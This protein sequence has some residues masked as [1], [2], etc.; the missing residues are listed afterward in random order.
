MIKFKKNYLEKLRTKWTPQED[1]QLLTNIIKYG[2]RWSYLSKMIKGRNEHSIKYHFFALLKKNGITLGEDDTEE[3]SSSNTMSEIFKILE[4][5]NKNTAVKISHNTDDKTTTLNTSSLCEEETTVTLN[6]QSQCSLK[7]N[8]NPNKC[9]GQPD[10][11][12]FRLMNYWH[13]VEEQRM[14]FQ[15]DL[16]LNSKFDKYEA[17]NTINKVFFKIY[18][19]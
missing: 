7:E 4:K 5:M 17:E 14:I 8:K 16:L 15:E 1:Y 9:P 19:L 10:V 13:R 11:P 6:Q 2:K 18:A 3:V 12:K